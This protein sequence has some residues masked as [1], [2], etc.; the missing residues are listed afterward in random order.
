[1]ILTESFQL[2]DKMVE[3]ERL[4]T[5]KYKY[6]Y[7]ENVEAF[8]RDAVAETYSLEAGEVTKGFDPSLDFRLNK[9]TVELKVTAFDD[10]HV[11]YARDNGDPSGIELSKA[12]VTMTLSGGYSGSGRNWKHVGKLRIFKTYQLREVIEPLKGNPLYCKEYPAH[13]G[14]RGSKCVVLNK[15]LLKTYNMDIGLFDIK[16]VKNKKGWII[17]YDFNN[18]TACGNFNYAR[19]QTWKWLR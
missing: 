11:E 3:I 10:L 17:A 18:V 16:L 2:F 4:R 15:E 13:D 12:Q 9:K 5:G 7:S 1:M 19:S 6:Q 8:I 14:G